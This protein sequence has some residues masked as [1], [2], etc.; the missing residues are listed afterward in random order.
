MLCSVLFC[1]VSSQTEVSTGYW[2]STNRSESKERSQTYSC[3]LDEG[4]DVATDGTT[5]AEQI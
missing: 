4:E 1:F 3:K 2:T 5:Q